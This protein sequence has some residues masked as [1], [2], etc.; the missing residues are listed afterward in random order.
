MSEPRI[1]IVK[2]SSLGDILH[3]MPVLRPLREKFPDAFIAWAVQVGE[4]LLTHNKD[5]DE[6]INIGR[7][8]G[9]IGG[10]R[11]IRE[12]KQ[13][14]RKYDFTVALDV[15]GLAKSGLVAWV[16]GAREI[17][18]FKGANCREL[19]W[20]FTNHRYKPPKD[21]HI[22]HQNMELLSY[23]DIKA[24]ADVP[25]LEVSKEDEAFVDDVIKRIHPGEGNCFIIVNPGVSRPNKRWPEQHFVRLC[26]LLIET[27]PHAVF[28]TSGTEEEYSL[29]EYIC[30][31]VSSETKPVPVPRL[32]LGQFVALAKRS[33]FFVG[34][35]TGPTHI[36]FAAG[37][38]SVFLFGP[39]GP[40]RNGGYESAH[41]QCVNI[42]S[43]SECIE[44]WDKECRRTNTC[45]ES[46]Q[47]E[48]VMKYVERLVME[49]K[50]GW[51]LTE[52]PSKETGKN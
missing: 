43:P 40:W 38:P 12:V 17:V 37:I 46:L 28:L 7:G 31:N 44:C 34:N 21:I 36:A 33:E 48:Q 50:P 24:S 42:I 16:S 20:L 49:G 26:E 23:F 14:L 52:K 27:Y 32:S 10:I 2:L 35:D 47:P 45:M 4:E 29:C 15:Q 5:L 39:T 11:W 13:L 51:V 6:V 19:N 9:I 22:A 25:G 41:G 3:A 1:L 8:K 30:D 18:G